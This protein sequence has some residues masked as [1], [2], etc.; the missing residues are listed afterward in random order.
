MRKLYLANGNSEFKS[1]FKFADTTTKII[2]SA[3]DNGIPAV[4]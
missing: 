1:E 4:S 2:L 3:F